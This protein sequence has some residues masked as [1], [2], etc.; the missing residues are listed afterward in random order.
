[1]DEKTCHVFISHV[2]EDDEV[3]QGLKDMLKRNGCDLR[4]SSIDSSKPNDATNH[5]YI[6]QQILAPR[7]C[8][9]GTMLVLISPD[10]H[11]SEWV[12][13]EIEYAEKNAKRIVGVWAR[14][15]QDCDVPE[16]LKKYADAVVGW[17][18]ERIMDAIGGK[19][20]NWSI[21][22]GTEQAP[23]SIERYSCG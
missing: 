10:T 19:I 17:N 8:W 23:L 20:N 5:D 22:D 1:M 21:P 3:L 18:T 13:W 16:N 14:G 4:D 7:I 2:H 12:D 6:K 9:A 11:T 15:G